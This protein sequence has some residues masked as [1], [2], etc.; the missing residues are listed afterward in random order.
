MAR[1]AVDFGTGNTVLARFNETKQQAETI[2]IP[3]ITRPMRYRLQGHTP[4]RLVHVVPSL[5]HFSKNETLIG[6]QVLFRGLSEHQDTVRWMKR[7]IAQRVTKRRKT[8]QGHKSPAEA[9]GEFLQLLLNYASDQI[10]LRQDEVTF[11]APV[12]AFE[13][14]QDWLWRVCETLGINRVRMFDE[15]T[16]SVLGYQGI[17]RGDE[18]Y[19][20]F[21]FGCGTLDVCAVRID[22]KAKSDKKAIQLGKAGRDLGGMDIDGW[23]VDDFCKRQRIGSHERK[24]LEMV[25]FRQAEAVKIQLSDPEVE[26]APLSVVNDLGRR[27][28]LLRTSY[29]RSCPDCERGRIGTHDTANDGCLGCILL[30]HGFLKQVRQTVD[31]SLENAALKAGMRRDDLVEVVVTGGTSLIPAVRHFLA[32]SFD[33]RIRF[34]SPF[35]S[36]ARGAC[37]GFVIPILQHDYAIESYN[38]DRQE[39]EFQ[40]LF[41]VGTEYPTPRDRARFWA[42]GSYDGMTKIELKIFEV[43]QA[44]RQTVGVAV[45]D[46]DG[47]LRDDSRVTSDYHYVCLNRDNPTFIVADPPISLLRDKRRFLCSFWVDNNR[48]LL[49]SVRDNLF[50]RTLLKDQAVVRL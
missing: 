43:S 29:R 2:Q 36:V 8:K 1:I 41:E 25:I 46:A 5:I 39:Y 9:G 23:L 26:E 3:E 21:D 30:A 48:R 27:P 16:A 31:R 28:R 22:L 10:D 34:E 37:Q 14:F 18:R 50:D 13:Y 40:T 32:E 33:G 42:K 35:D 6:E 20:V 49:V 15:A 7:G 47:A 24:Q 12:E 11:T 45:V 17:A 38:R 44:K 19:L 4:E